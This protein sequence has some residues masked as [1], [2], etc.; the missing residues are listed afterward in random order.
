[1]FLYKLICT[2]LQNSQITYGK[3]L[4]DNK[5]QEVL[6]KAAWNVDDYRCI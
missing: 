4:K 1:M 6:K 5:S 2:G 3:R